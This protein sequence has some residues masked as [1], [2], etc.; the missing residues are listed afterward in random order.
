MCGINYTKKNDVFMNIYKFVLFCSGEAKAVTVK[1][2]WENVRGIYMLKTGKGFFVS[3]LVFFC[4]FA[5]L[6]FGVKSYKGNSNTRGGQN[7][8]GSEIYL[9][10]NYN[11]S[12]ETSVEKPDNSVHETAVEYRKNVYLTFDDGPSEQT[13]KVLEI[14]KEYDVVAT[15]FVIGDQINEETEEIIQ[16]EIEQNCLIGV[17]TCC[18]EAAK[19][20]ESADSYYEDVMKARDR[21]E[22]ITGKKAEFYRFPW[23]SNNCYV[24]P[25]R[26]EIVKRLGSQKMEYVDWNVSGEDSVG[27]PDAESILHEVKKTYDSVEEPVILLHDSSINEETV[28]ALPSIIELYLDQGYTF[29]TLDQRKEPCHF[30]F[31]G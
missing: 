4:G 5:L 6:L 30:G 24:S 7:S 9:G 2:S 28:K 16:R 13:E 17:H 25:F 19:I 15:F 31:Q 27:S 3:L 22:E 8:S 1:T 21:L 14:L 29:S 20:Y 11:F 23:G 10:E 18:H 26:K 12:Q